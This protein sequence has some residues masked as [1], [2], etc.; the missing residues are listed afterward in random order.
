MSLQQNYR[1]I[2]IDRLDPDAST[3][4]DLSTL[5]PAD[6]GDT[7]SIRSSAEAQ[8]L[9][10]QIRQL[11]RGGDAEGALRGALENVPYGA[12]DRAKE[13]HLAT[14][15]EILQSIKQ[16]EMTPLLSNVYRSERGSEMLDVLMKYL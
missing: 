15:T 1:L 9:A 10:G 16:S 3:N 6:T 4:F 2:N 5:V 14:V 7:A 11:L 12:D 8:A 13:V